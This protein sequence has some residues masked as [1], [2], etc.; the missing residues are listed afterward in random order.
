MAG[1]NSLNGQAFNFS[2]EVQLTV[3]E[4]TRKVLELVGRSDLEPSI[5]GEAQNEIPH[6]YLSAEKAR[7]VLGWRSE[8]SID[9]GLGRTI[10]WYRAF[11]SQDK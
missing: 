5:L 3:L 6:Q 9:E 8:Y 11:L 1:N 4:M 7:S 2:N 10:E